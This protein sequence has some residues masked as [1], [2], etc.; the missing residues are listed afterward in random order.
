MPVKGDA[1]F[2]TL[3]DVEAVIQARVAAYL[4]GIEDDEERHDAESDIREH[5]TVG[6]RQLDAISSISV[7]L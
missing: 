6:H 5:F 4:A 3:E 1:S 2:I 7:F